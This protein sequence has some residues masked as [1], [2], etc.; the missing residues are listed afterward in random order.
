[1]Q[2][3]TLFYA[4][5]ASILP[6]LDT[7]AELPVAT[8]FCYPVT[9]IGPLESAGRRVC[10][11]FPPPTQDP[12]IY[13]KNDT[14]FLELNAGWGYHLGD[15]WNGSLGGSS[16]RGYPVY[17]AAD[18]ELVYAR[19]LG[20]GAPH[21]WG[22]VMMVKHRLPEGEIVYSFY[23]HL[24]EMLIPGG[25]DLL[26]G[27]GCLIGKGHQIGK[28]GDANGFYPGM[29]HL[30]FAI[31]RTFDLDD[32]DITPGPGYWPT[33]N[34]PHIDENYYNPTVFIENRLANQCSLLGDESL[35]GCGIEVVLQATPSS[36]SSPLNGVDLRATVNGPPG[37]TTYIFY[38]D[39]SDA[40][41]TIT[42]GFVARY[43]NIEA[44]PKVAV[45]ACSYTSGGTYTPKVIVERN[46]QV[47][48][49][50]T[51][52]TVS[53]SS[54]TCWPLTVLRNNANAGSLPLLGAP[55]SPG[56]PAGKYQRDFQLLTAVVPN[57]GWTVGS[58]EGTINN[59]SKAVANAVIMPNGP[60]TL[61]INYVTGSPACYDLNRDHSGQG[62]DPEA[63]PNKSPGCSTGDY[64]AGEVIAVEA[65]PDSGW[66][67]EEWDGT[68]NDASTSVLN[69]V[70][71]PAHN[72]TVEVI[73]ED[74][75][76]DEYLLTV[77]VVGTGHGRVM[78][79]PGGISCGNW[80]G[81][82]T[83]CTELYEEDEQ[84][85]LTPEPRNSSSVFTSWEGHS[86]CNDGNVRLN[87]AKNCRARFSTTNS[88]CRPLTLWSFGEGTAPVASPT[89][90]GGCSPGYYSA[91][92]AITLSGA[93]P[94][95]GWR[96]IS[97]QSTNN[98]S[99]T[100]STN[101][102]TMPNF[103][104][105]VIVNYGRLDGRPT[106]ETR[107]GVANG[108]TSAIVSLDTNPN[109]HPMYWYAKYGLTPEFGSQ[110]SDF[111]RAA[112]YV[113]NSHSTQIF[114]LTC[115]TQYFVAAV[116]EGAQGTTY[117]DILSFWTGACP[118]AA[119]TAATGSVDQIS[120]TS[121]RLR[122]AVNANGLS[123]EAWFEWGETSSLGNSTPHRAIGSLNQDVNFSESLFGLSCDSVYFARVRASN[124][125][126]S[127]NGDAV[128]FRTDPCVLTG[129][130]F[131]DGFETGDTSEWTLVGPI[132]R[133]IFTDNFN[134]GV[135]DPLSWTWSGSSVTEVSGELHIDVDQTDNGGNASTVEIPILPSGVISLTRRARVFAANQNFDGGLVFTPVNHEDRRFGVSY[136]E[137][138]PGSF[139]GECNA[140]GF[141]LFRNNANSHLCNVQGT[142]VTNRIPGI[143]NQWFDEQISYN[144]ESGSLIYSINGQQKLSL[145]VGPLPS[146]VNVMKIHMHTWGWH[147][148]HFQYSDN[149][150]VRQVA[151]P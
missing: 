94:V 61:K 130:L 129:L 62:D 64:V 78:S 144:P 108:Q 138:F 74:L 85:Q 137:Y 6:M 87:Q 147:T 83:N 128:Q 145:N 11:V 53:S 148:G 110:T 100:S 29:D 117:G 111:P 91:N 82:G 66:T 20:N 3:S 149:F 134:D 73:Y 104:E 79:Q 143:W 133:V 135:L 28:I 81:G 21:S 86:D 123:T 24:L 40:G 17:S 54:S 122:G 115:G 33:N 93:Q 44:N 8:S 71:M 69:S 51:T 55:N 43:E 18:G 25:C 5:L 97:W 80:A 101:S 102:L 59:S 60:H 50:R 65:D 32:P 12:S 47:A 41:T 42:P 4:I 39:R 114:G 124:S 30:H 56:C 113:T 121:A 119:P 127:T 10:D 118:V 95:S 88:T 48:E 67:V 38:C 75:V 77:E 116:G 112:S 46:G 9:P 27:T 140:Q 57:S 26:T 84:V 107:F 45:D 120:Q 31:R 16:D 146:G 49:D 103:E 136:A 13:Y 99:S 76:L 126:G 70:V 150:E 96:I 22:K 63:T 14:E 142:D 35:A 92:T 23:G 131:R 98:D 1:M 89:N 139:P 2:R 105:T 7:W 68:V 109:G 125:E 34:D 37:L 132:S 151:L 19:D 90:S 36:G 58:W 15:D 106:V 141:A 52:V 72:H